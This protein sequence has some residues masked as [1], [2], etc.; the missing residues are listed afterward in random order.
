M[1]RHPN[2]L[3]GVDPPLGV[4]PWVPLPPPPAVGRCPSWLAALAAG[5]CSPTVEAHLAG[6]SLLGEV[7]PGL[8]ELWPAPRGELWIGMGYAHL[9]GLAA[10]RWQLVGHW[11]PGWAAGAVS[12]VL[13][14][15][16]PARC[17]CPAA[18]SPPTQCPSPSCRN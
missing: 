17:S 13:L 5:G 6:G 12:R 1:F 7:E 3:L 4:M 16:R 2:G 18:A 10:H 8:R 9:C 11:A 14:G 15:V